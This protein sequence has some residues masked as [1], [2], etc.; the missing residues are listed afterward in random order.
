MAKK[1]DLR[2]QKFGRLLVLWDSK[3]RTKCGHIVWLC[4]CSC[5]K[6]VKVISGNLRYGH[7]R[8]CGCLQKEL[9]KI[10]GKANLGHG[11]RNSRLYVTW[12]N[13]KRKCYNPNAINFKNYGGRGIGICKEWLDPE[14]GYLNFRMWAMANGYAVG[15]RYYLISRKDHRKNFSPDNCQI[16]SR[17]GWLEL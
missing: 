12:L 2:N 9:A 11:D 10:H 5:G 1:I 3:K 7:T 6:Q 15:L 14:K 13:F 4:K 16:T 8:S 17:V